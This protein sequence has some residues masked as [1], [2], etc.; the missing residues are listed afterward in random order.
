MGAE[1]LGSL[2]HKE[3]TPA[4]KN[5]LGFCYGEKPQGF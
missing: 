1:G 3:Q 4:S 2:I 5:L